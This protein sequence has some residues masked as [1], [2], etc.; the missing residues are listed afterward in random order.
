MPEMDDHNNAHVPALMR[1]SARLKQLRRERGL[2]LSQL[3]AMTQ[4]S[5]AYLYR[6]EE[7]ER[8]P[9]LPALLKMAETY[10]VSASSLLDEAQVDK[11]LALH[12][13]AAEW[14]GREEDGSGLMA[15][16]NAPPTP[17]SRR[18]RLKEPGDGASE[19]AESSPEQYIGAAL[20]GCFSMSLAAD[21]RAAGHE[22]SEIHTEAMVYLEHGPSAP[23]ISSIKLQCSVASC[24]IDEAELEAIGQRTRQ[25]CV[26][27]RALSSVRITLEISMGNAKGLHQ[28]G[29][30]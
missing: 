3:A 13:A 28:A 18:S 6:L 11:A 26:V 29:E 20:A 12:R 16:S 1:L 22:P 14:T 27:G 17:Y 24:G 15:I 23:A 30:P 5:E 10:G 4:L 25:T 8:S 7:G 2:T 9:S 19:R 21:L